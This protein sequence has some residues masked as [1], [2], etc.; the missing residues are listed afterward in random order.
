MIKLRDYQED[1]SSKACNLL[2]E[3]HIAYLSMQVR[4]GKT[5]TALAAAEKFGA[6]NVLFISKLKALPGIR[7]DYEA[8]RPSF[9][10]DLINFESVGKCSGSY[11]L[12]IIDEAHSLGTFPKPSKRTVA[13]KQKIG[14]MPVMFLSGTPTPESYSQIF[15][16]FWV[17]FYSP[18]KSECGDGVRA[19]YKFAKIYCDVTP[20]MINGFSVSDYSKAR[21]EDVMRVV[22][23]YL[24]TYTQEDAGFKAE[25]HEHELMCQ[26]GLELQHIFRTLKRDKC[27]S[28]PVTGIKILA[29]SP[30]NML[31]KL[32]QL[33]GGTVIDVNGDHLILDEFKVQAI[34]E[35]FRGKRIAVFYVYQSERDLLL[36]YF[37]DR[38]T[39]SPEEFQKG[40]YDVFVGQIRS[41]REGVRL[42]TA[43]AIVFYSMEF[44]YLS[45]EQ[46]RNRI[47]SK[48][49]KVPADVWFAVSQMGIEKKILQ[50]V[51]SKS[52][53]TLSYYLKA[54]K[55][56]QK[57]G[58]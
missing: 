26:S 54:E 3:R 52:D 25:I 8:F 41:V 57:A 20:M 50:A 14:K 23:P 32:A 36:Q 46:G 18:F 9:H 49:R 48:E 16:Q 4:T 31:G 6:K 15:N 42:D 12:F 40:G 47:M 5:L 19:F 2:C 51:H 29:G 27:F 24:L 1:I 11:D 7:Q 44:S 56:E 38:V 39:T 45:Y 55:D 17:S 30:A 35:H 43:D 21:K 58:K 34:D 37:G 10:I 28:D 13:I 22:S 33:S 53:F